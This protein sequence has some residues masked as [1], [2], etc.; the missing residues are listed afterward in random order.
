MTGEPTHTTS[1]MAQ[2]VPQF[3]SEKSNIY[4]ASLSGLFNLLCSIFKPRIVRK[5]PLQPMHTERKKW[6]C[7][8]QL[9]QLLFEK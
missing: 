7:A 6:C 1:E 4:Y 5:A 3:S 2:C 8:P 9:Y